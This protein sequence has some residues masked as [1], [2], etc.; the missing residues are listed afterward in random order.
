MSIERNEYNNLPGDATVIGAAERRTEEQTAE[1][2]KAA[3]RRGEDLVQ[4]MEDAR[5]EELMGGGAG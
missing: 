2:A 3:M 5:W 1:E 4:R